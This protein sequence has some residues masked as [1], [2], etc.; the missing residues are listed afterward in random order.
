M[1]SSELVQSLGDWV[2][3]YHWDAFW[4]LTFRERYN[5]QPVIRRITKWADR[6]TLSEPGTMSWLFFLEMSQFGEIHA[7]GLTRHERSSRSQMWSRW[8]R[9]S[10]H[11][12]GLKYDPKLGANYYIAKYLTKQQLSWIIDGRGVNQGG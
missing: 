6:H 1:L 10:G 5:E 9:D 8:F 11:A 2:S 4:T 7:H 12:R 3:E